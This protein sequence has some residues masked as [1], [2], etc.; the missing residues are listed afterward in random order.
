VISSRRSSGDRE[1]AEEAVADA[2]HSAGGA[3]FALFS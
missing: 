2:R 1:N 3:L